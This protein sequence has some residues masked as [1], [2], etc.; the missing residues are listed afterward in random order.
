MNVQ[1][2]PRTGSSLQD[3]ALAL[4]KDPWA[5]YG[6][7]ATELHSVARKDAEALQL[8]CMN[9]LLEKR[10]G[11]ISTLA[12]FAVRCGIGH[13]IRALARGH[14]S[15]ARLLVELGPDQV[16]ADLA[17]ALPADAAIDGLHFFTFGGIAR[18]AAWL[19]AHE[20]DARPP[21]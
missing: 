1:T 13:S 3:D 21:R 19:A 14:S 10:R 5:F 9:I 16:V 18:T 20:T 7:S 12:K 8:A 4:M 15:L 2:K 17:A 11:E 6:N